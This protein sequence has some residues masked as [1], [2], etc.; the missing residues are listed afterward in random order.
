MYFLNFRSF[1]VAPSEHSFCIL[2]CPFS[3]GLAEGRERQV[4]HSLP[5]RSFLSLGLKSKSRCHS[6]RNPYSDLG[7]IC[8]WCKGHKGGC[9]VGPWSLST[10]FPGGERELTSV[11]DRQELRLQPAPEDYNRIEKTLAPSCCCGHCK[12]HHA[13]HCYHVV[14]L[15][16]TNLHCPSY[17]NIPS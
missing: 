14:M 2:E 11:I 3:A 17:R 10:V 9:F 13:T 12:C 6:K 1:L 8:G 16:W 4:I 7:W 5:S 15:V